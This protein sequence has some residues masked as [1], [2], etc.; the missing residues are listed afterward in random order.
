MKTPK[1][2]KMAGTVY[3]DLS[4]MLNNKWEEHKDIFP[5]EKCPI[6]GAT[7]SLKITSTF[8][9][10]KSDDTKTVVSTLGNESI[11]SVAD[12]SAEMSDKKIEKKAEAPKKV[13]EKD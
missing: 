2:E 13:N 11:I 10:V 5:L 4:K 3:V 9:G 1:G 7:V 6:S 12:K 8:L